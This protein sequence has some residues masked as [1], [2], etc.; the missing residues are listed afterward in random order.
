LGYPE[1]AAWIENHP[2]EYQ[3]GLFRGFVASS[4]PSKAYNHQ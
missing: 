4:R 2:D 3:E 1:V